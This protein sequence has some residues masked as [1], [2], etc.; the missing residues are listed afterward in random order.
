MA[1]TVIKFRPLRRVSKTGKI[2]VASYGLWNS[3]RVADNNP[4]ELIVN[5]E[6]KDF[7]KQEYVYNHKGEQL[8][9]YDYNPYKMPMYKP[10]IPLDRDR[11][12]IIKEHGGYGL[13]YKGGYVNYSA[14]GLDCEGTPCLSHYTM[15]YV[16]DHN[17]NISDFEPLTVHMAI[18]WYG[19]FL[20]NL[21]NA[22]IKIL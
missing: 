1:I 22:K 13:S 21:K 15:D 11:R 4:F 14:K 12:E 3:V 2:A 6:Y 16:A 7:P 8:F 5:N 19:W 9:F 10:G 18:E 20:L 17:Y